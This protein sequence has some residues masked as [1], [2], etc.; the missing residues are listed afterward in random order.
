MLC[1]QHQKIVP[2]FAPVRS[3]L[4]TAA[5]L[6][7][8]DQVEAG[9]RGLDGRC[10]GLPS[11]Q[12]K[13]H[14]TCMPLQVHYLV[15]LRGCSAA[16]LFQRIHPLAYEAQRP[17]SRGLRQRSH[18]HV[19]HPQNHAAPEPTAFSA[20]GSGWNQ[21]FAFPAIPSG[22]LIVRRAVLTVRRARRKGCRLKEVFPIIKRKISCVISYLKDRYRSR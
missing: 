5:L 21:T 16:T 2:G 8:S 10:Q 6:P 22:Q 18:Q 11:G 20:S 3:L 14:G 15:R 19:R 13:R 17:D 1:G 9:E 4:P 12:T 7:D